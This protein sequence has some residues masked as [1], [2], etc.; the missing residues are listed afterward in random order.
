MAA[1]LLNVGVANIGLTEV[2]AYT[3]PEGKTTML[4]GCSVTNIYGAIVP[5]DVLVRK[6]EIDIHLAKERRV[7]NGKSEE[8]VAG[9]I[10]LASGDILI[11]RAYVDGSFDAL[12]SIAEGV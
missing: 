9:K 11:L 8:M 7:Q 1:S 6:S 12:I 3:V 5:L 10:V 4:L 2:A